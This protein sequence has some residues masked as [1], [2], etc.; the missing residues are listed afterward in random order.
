MRVRIWV[1]GADGPSHDF[2]LVQPPRV[3]E[4]ISIAVGG[5][6]EEGLVEDVSWQLLGIE[7]AAVDLPLDAEPVGSVSMVHVICKPRARAEVGVLLAGVASA[8]NR[9]QQEADDD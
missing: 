4:H 8:E 2:E 7:R 5:S 9:T 6:I 3:G 1:S